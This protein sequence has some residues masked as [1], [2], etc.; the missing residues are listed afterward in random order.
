MDVTASLLAM[1]AL[2]ASGKPAL[3]GLLKDVIRRSGVMCSKR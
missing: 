1:A 2:R 3:Q